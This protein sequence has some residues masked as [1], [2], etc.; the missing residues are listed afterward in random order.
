MRD[1]LV[2]F[3]ETAVVFL[4]L[5][6]ALSIATAAYA[7]SVANGLAHGTEGVRAMALE[8]TQALLARMRPGLDRQ[9]A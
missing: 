7:I 8:K 9:R 2:T 3:L 1:Q 4:L 5:T 6:N